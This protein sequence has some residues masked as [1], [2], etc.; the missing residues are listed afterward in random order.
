MSNAMI[1]VGIAIGVVAMAGA[2]AYGTANQQNYISEDAVLAPAAEQG[3]LPKT[4]VLGADLNKE[5]WHE[6]PFGDLAQKIREQNGR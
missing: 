4:G 1:Y 3:L 5:K 2:I 6:D